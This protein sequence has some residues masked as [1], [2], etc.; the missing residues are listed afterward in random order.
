MDLGLKGRVA[1]VAAS[2]RGLGRA[3]AE[4]LAWEG[5]NLVMCARSA[6][7]LEEARAAIERETGCQVAALATDVSDPAQ[8]ESLVALG[9]GEVVEARRCWRL[10]PRCGGLVWGCLEG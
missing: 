2:S 7:P 6:G 5:C 9:L 1:L 4:E 10:L 8:V 3:V